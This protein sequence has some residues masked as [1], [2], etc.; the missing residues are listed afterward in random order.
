MHIFRKFLCL[1]KN[2]LEWF[3]PM[4]GRLYL[5]PCMKYEVHARILN[6]RSVLI[7]MV[8]KRLPLKSE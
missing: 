5:E 4:K 6:K 1:V 7:E 3:H 2:H 8:N